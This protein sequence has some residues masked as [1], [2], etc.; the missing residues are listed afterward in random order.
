VSMSSLRRTFGLAM[1]AFFR[2]VA[3]F[4][5]LRWEPLRYFL[6]SGFA[7][8]VD[9]AIFLL[10]LKLFLCHGRW[11]PVLVLFWVFGLHT[12]LVFGMYLQGAI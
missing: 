10:G 9:T 4:P 1:S 5:W 6:I 12:N 2:D 11:L 3:A 8:V 7:F